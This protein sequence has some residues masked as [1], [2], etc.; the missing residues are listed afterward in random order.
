[1]SLEVPLPDMA[2]AACLVR[3]RVLAHLASTDPLGIRLRAAAGRFEADYHLAASP[4]RLRTNDPKVLS[5]ARNRLLT[6]E[7]V[8]GPDMA[9]MAEMLVLDRFTLSALRQ[10]T[11]AGL[12]DAR[13]V[14][15]ELAGVYRLTGWGQDVGRAFAS[16]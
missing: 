15:V 9:G 3:V 4:G 2:P 14:L 12:E 6:V 7:R 1:M 10:R 16:S 13:G 5:A 8:L 11:G